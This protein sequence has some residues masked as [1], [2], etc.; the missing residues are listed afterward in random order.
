VLPGRDGTWPSRCAELTLSSRCVPADSACARA[1]RQSP[2]HIRQNRGKALK[3]CD[4][5]LLLGVK[6]DFRLDYGRSLPTRGC[7]IIAVSRA[8]DDLT[9][10]AGT[11]GETHDQCCHS[12]VCHLLVSA[13]TSKAR[14]HD[15]SRTRA[16]AR[17]PGFWKPTLAAVADPCLFALALLDA[18]RPAASAEA[19]SAW[20]A[21]LTD[22]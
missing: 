17:P 2:W 5:L 21:Q 4:C 8:P 15:A 18:P 1:G 7:P 13:V 3:Q 9:Q 14:A 11:L 12:C 19:W 20:G 16:N 22:I 6:A 10:N